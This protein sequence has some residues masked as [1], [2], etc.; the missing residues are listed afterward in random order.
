MYRAAFHLFLAWTYEEWFIEMQDIFNLWATYKGL[1]AH[2][3]PQAEYQAIHLA[4][5]DLD[6]EW[7]YV[8]ID[9]LHRKFLYNHALINWRWL[10]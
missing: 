6:C 1:S 4:K 2:V 5:Y 10:N 9:D 3:T 7:H 8:W